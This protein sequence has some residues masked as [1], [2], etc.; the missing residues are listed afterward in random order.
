MVVSIAQG[1]LL[2]GPLFGLGLWWPQTTTAPAAPAPSFP[3]SLLPGENARTLLNRNL[4]S[5]WDI[6]LFQTKHR[7]YFYVSKGWLKCF[8][9]QKSSLPSNYSVTLLRKPTCVLRRLPKTAPPTPRCFAWLLPC[10][11]YH[12]SSHR[13]PRVKLRKRPGTSQRLMDW[14]CWWCC[15]YGIVHF[16]LE[17]TNYAILF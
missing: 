13:T 16:N 14:W 7:F 5:L 9:K 15:S 4:A 3:R 1:Q 10:T 2:A 11:S 8:S 12:V 17:I 6:F